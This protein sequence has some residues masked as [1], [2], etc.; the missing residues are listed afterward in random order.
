MQLQVRKQI[1]STLLDICKTACSGLFIWMVIKN[2][3]PIT[4]QN[5]AAVTLLTGLTM[6]L[7]GTCFVLS[8]YLVV[9]TQLIKAE[10]G[11]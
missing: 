9:L 8:V 3:F 11:S 10:E 7:F 1:V 2:L 6:A 5:D 4:E